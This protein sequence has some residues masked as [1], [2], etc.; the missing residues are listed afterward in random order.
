[1][2][3]FSLVKVKLQTVKG[4]IQSF[5]LQHLGIWITSFG[6]LSLVCMPYIATHAATPALY[7]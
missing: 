3:V 1:M 7:I 5:S 2:S 6:E 4:E